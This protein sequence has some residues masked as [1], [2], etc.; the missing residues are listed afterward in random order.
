M[1]W[2]RDTNFFAL[3]PWLALMLVWWLGGWLLASHCFELKRRERLLAGFGFGLL[4]YAW[5]ANLLGHWLSAQLTY[6]LPA[7]LVVLLGGLAWYLGEREQVLDWRDVRRVWPWLLAGL[8]LVFFFVRVG[9]GLAIF[10]EGKNLSLISIMGAGDIPPRFFPRSEIPN[11]SHLSLRLPFTGRQPDA[12]GPDVALER[13][14]PRQSHCM[15]LRCL[16]SW[17][18]GADVIL[19]T[20]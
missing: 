15:G 13:L 9:K 11:Q 14:R 12:I 3:L 6:V 19:R 2:F 7:L 5:F 10:D 20:S 8:T 4:L 17:P 1:Y 16:G 18:G